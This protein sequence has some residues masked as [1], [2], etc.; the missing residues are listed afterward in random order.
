M[1]EFLNITIKVHGEEISISLEDAEQLYKELDALFGKSNITPFTLDPIKYSWSS[2]TCASLDG[3]I[4][5]PNTA[6]K[7]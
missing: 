6:E 7:K 1:T 5:F 4:T 2:P 3:V